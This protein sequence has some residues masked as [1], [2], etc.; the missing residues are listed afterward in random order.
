MSFVYHL[1]DVHSLKTNERQQSKL[2]STAANWMSEGNGQKRKAQDAGILDI[3]PSKQIKEDAE[4]YEQT[5][6]KFLE[7]PTPTAAPIV[8]PN[9]LS[10]FPLPPLTDVASPD[11]VPGLISEA[12]SPPDSCKPTLMGDEALFSQYLRS[13]S[14]SC[15]SAKDIRYKDGNSDSIVGNDK[16][17]RA[18][19]LDIRE[20]GLTAETDPPL[21]NLTDNPDLKSNET[22]TEIPK[23]R[24]RLRLG[25]PK[26]QPKI[27]IQFRR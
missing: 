14:S 11:T 19:A 13:R 10:E 3:H 24:V 27:T 16:R 6:R 8:P 23:A 2:V 12:T 20:A 25:Q 17:G 22:P 1:S 9:P 4:I 21:A 18:H 15:S 5:P 26:P 7:G